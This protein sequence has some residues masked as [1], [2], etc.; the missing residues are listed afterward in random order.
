MILPHNTA[1]YRT[2]APL[3]AR[4][5]IGGAFLFAATM[6][7]PGTEMFDIEVGMLAAAGWP[8]ATVS[9]ILA[10]IL[11][12]GAGL[13]IILGYHA[14]LAA[15][16]LVLFTALVIVLFYWNFTQ[17]GM[18]ALISHLELMAGLIYL[19]VYGAQSVALKRD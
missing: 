11:E 9:L 6:K 13:A 17:E 18:P 19:S 10:G 8:L 7:I 5:I 15:F 14:R 12:A 1:S 2:W 3:I 4:I 16:L